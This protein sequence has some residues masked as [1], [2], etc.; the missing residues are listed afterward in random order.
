MRVTG[1]GE[2]E[3]YVRRCGNRS[4]TL[5]VNES[6]EPVTEAEARFSQRTQPPFSEPG[7]AWTRE[8]K[9]PVPAGGPPQPKWL[10]D[11]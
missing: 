8:Q 2:S 3:L 9:T 5:P 6:L 10:S 1:C 7:C 11:P 4:G